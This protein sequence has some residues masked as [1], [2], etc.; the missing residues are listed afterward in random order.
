M[1]SELYIRGCV[2]HLVCVCSEKPIV[3][4]ARGEVENPRR[5]P[6]QPWRS[7]KSPL[8]ETSALIADSSQFLIIRAGCTPAHNDR[9]AP[10]FHCT[11][12]DSAHSGA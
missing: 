2:F 7:I 3:Q 6:G 5:L 9:D 11:C 8:C 12:C 1:P 10:E 4:K